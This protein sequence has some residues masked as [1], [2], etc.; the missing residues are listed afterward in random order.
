GDGDNEE[1]KDESPMEETKSHPGEIAAASGQ[2]G[3][4]GSDVT[5]P[6]QST[7]PTDGVNVST[8]NGQVLQNLL[9]DTF[10]SNIMDHIQENGG[11]DKK[12]SSSTNSDLL[13]IDNSNMETSEDVITS[14]TPQQS[15][16]HRNGVEYGAVDF[17]SVD[18]VKQN[19]ATN[20]LLD[21]SEFDAF[22]TNNVMMTAT[23]PLTA[24]TD[25]EQILDLGT[26]P[27]TGK[28]SNEDNVNSNVMNNGPA[29]P[30]I[31]FQDNLA[32]KSDTNSV[33]DLLS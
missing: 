31:A 14:A 28:L 26:A 20:N 7:L 5:P 18:N 4:D 6:A 10:S 23:Q 11:S 27:A 17:V 8:G 15:N 24:A 3:E 13:L 25:F 29:P 30:F 19:N 12:M 33:T 21:L 22:S 1:G 2:S 32:K 16:G 9:T